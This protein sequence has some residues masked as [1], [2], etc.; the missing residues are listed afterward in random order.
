MTDA[1]SRK[2]AH[3][4]RTYGDTE[5]AF[6]A[7]VIL[8]SGLLTNDITLKVGELHLPC[9]LYACSMRG[10]RVIAEV[11]EAVSG[12]L[13]RHNN[14]AALRFGFRPTG[15]P[16]DITFFVSCRVESLSE[17]HPHKP[18]FRFI[19]LSFLQQPPDALISILGSL[20]EIA[21]NEVRRRDERIVVN[22]ENM[23]KIGLESRESCVAIAGSTRRCIVRDLSFSGAKILVTSPGSVTGES[24]VMLKLSKC[25]KQ[26]PTVLDGS[27]VRVEQ[28]EGRNDVV[29]L[30]IHYSSEP[31][32]SYRQRIN[33]Y[34]A[35]QASPG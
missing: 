23:K 4:Y 1:A 28:V 35:G 12:E 7:R 10:A 11:G 13:A 15:E 21:A 30:S 16:T 33:S 17:Y 9:V 6:N 19:S 3:F 24:R 20:I 26:D 8:S 27:V 14:I 22:D 2:V 32:I 5:I 31:P 18:Q 25:E 29:A 34:F